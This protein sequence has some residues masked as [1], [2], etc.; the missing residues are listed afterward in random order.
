MGLFKYLFLF[1]YKQKAPS[2]L[3]S[4]RDILFVENF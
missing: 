3:L 2:E 4:R 1:L